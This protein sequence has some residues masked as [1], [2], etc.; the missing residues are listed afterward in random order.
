VFHFGC[1][2]FSLKYFSSRSNS[3]HYQNHSDIDVMIDDDEINDDDVV[4]TRSWRDITI[5]DSKRH[6]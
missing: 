3:R 5:R 2:Q 4:C 6:Y 1:E